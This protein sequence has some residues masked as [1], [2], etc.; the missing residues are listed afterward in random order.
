[1]LRIGHGG[2]YKAPTMEKAESGRLRGK[3]DQ[4]MFIVP[5]N[6]S[7]LNSNYLVRSGL[8]ESRSF[9]TLKLVGLFF[10]LIVS[11]A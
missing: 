4:I 10:V 11:L 3:G 5:K 7:C 1:M 6:D 2:L 8:R 9:F